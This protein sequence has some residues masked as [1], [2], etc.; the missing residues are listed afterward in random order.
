MVMSLGAPGR[1]TPVD[2]FTTN[3][4]RWVL[5]RGVYTVPAGQS[6]TRISFNPGVGEDNSS[7]FLDSVSVRVSA[8]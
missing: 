3:S 8:P 1:E 7:N 4:D 2:S 5:Y 6:V